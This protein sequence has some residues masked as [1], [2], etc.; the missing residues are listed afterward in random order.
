MRVCIVG[1]GAIGSLFAAHLA[2]L[3]D[4][5]VW[6][7]EVNRAHVDAINATGLRLSGFSQVHS[8]P[9]A[10]AD[11]T[12]IPPCDFGIV[13]TKSQHTRAAMEATASVFRDAAVCSVQNGVGNEEIIAGFAP[14]VMR[15]TTFPAGRIVEPGHVQQDTGGKTWMGPFEPK[16][17]SMAE[18]EALAA[19]LTESGMETLAMADAR[20]AQWTKL[21]FNAATNPIGALTGLPHG[22]ACDQ[23]QLRRLISGLAAE[24][25]A[26]A[27]A[28]GITPDSDP[29]KL[30]D[31]A[32]EVAYH[33]KASM[34]QDV[35]GKRA[36]EVD[37]LNGGIVRFGEEAGVP[38][39]LNR[40]IQALIH[41]L[42][43]SWTRK[44]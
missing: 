42:E 21:I 44:D 26:V 13:A 23:P 37:A 5:E 33:H 28:L 7:Y 18:V 6:A 43:H 24:G 29:E 25:V 9:K 4:V 30:I 22:V 39:P 14:R 11:A 40:A 1:C 20:G 3:K 8:H 41:G 27:K 17:A 32:R 10:S 38:T 12:K 16:P 31:H 2:R 35:L 15:G 36:T 34:L 19:K